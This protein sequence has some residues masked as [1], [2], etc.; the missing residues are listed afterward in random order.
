M[1]KIP[2]NGQPLVI[3]NQMANA[4]PSVDKT[5]IILYIKCEFKKGH[6]DMHILH[7]YKADQLMQQE[8]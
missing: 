8:I 6:L 2:R 1:R 5:C 7:M 4:H 3:S